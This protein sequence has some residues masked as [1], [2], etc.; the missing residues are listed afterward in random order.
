MAK[1][2]ERK[3]VNDRYK[4]KVSHIVE[5]DEVWNEKFQA[6]VAEFQILPTYKGKLGDDATLLEFL[7]KQDELTIEL[8]KLYL[9]AHMNSDADTRDDNYQQMQRRIQ[10]ALVMISSSLSFVETEICLRSEEQ[11]LAL[12]KQPEF[13]DYSYM[14][15]KL[16]KDKKHVLSEEVEKVLADV[17]SFS[18]GFREAFSM[19]DNA[20]VK[21]KKITIDGVETEMSHGV[22]GYALQ[23]GDQAT[24]QAAFESMFGA[25]KDHINTIAALY[26]NHVKKDAFYAKTKKYDSCLSMALEQNDVDPAAYENLIKTVDEN[27]K[28]MHKY[29]AFRKK[30]LGVEKL[31]MWDLHTSIVKDVD[32]A[33]PY[34]KAYKMVK[35]ALKP[36]GEEY[37]GLLTEAYENG[38]IDVCET[39]GKR[40]GA[41][42]TSTYGCHPFVLLNYQQTSHDIFTIAHELGHAMHSHYS[43]ENQPFS[44]SDYVIFVAE[45]ASTVNEVLMLK[46]LISKTKDVEMKKYLL[47][48]YLDMFRTTLFRQTMFAEFELE[49][50]KLAEADAPITAN[51]LSE[52]YYNLNKKYYGKAVTHNDLI[53]Y[54]WARIPH[55]Y[56]SFYVYQYATGITAAISIANNILKNGEKAFKGYKQFLSA[57]GSM[58]PIEILKLA[59]VDLTTEEPFKVAMKEFKDT[60]NELIKI[61]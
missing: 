34:E 42:S 47:S 25:Y 58:P 35:E 20:D 8:I 52:I 51:A 15:E 7:K 38:W 39:K 53:R 12:S 31:N 33:V 57:G 13:S 41:Y 45:I 4:W 54:E 21:F 56:T 10:S 1:V 37:Q 17:G 48:Y 36:L 11:L 6:I 55:F 44:K 23:S 22:Y 50:H 27:C 43:Q 29:M 18:G 60:L 40:S 32:I 3:K 2:L 14:L 5:N 28:Y 61:Y 24:R 59:G 49:A 30:A 9:Y 16:A 26:G 46:Y 19:F